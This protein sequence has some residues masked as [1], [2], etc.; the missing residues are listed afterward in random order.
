[1]VFLQGTVIGLDTAIFIL[2][3]SKTK[4]ADNHYENMPIQIHVY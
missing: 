3:V 1:M 4:M 2:W